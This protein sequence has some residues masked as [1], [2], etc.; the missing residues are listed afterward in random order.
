MANYIAR[1]LEEPLLR[2]SSQFPV[3]VLTGP[4]QCGKTTLLRHLQANDRRYVSLDLM[5]NRMLAKEDP[6]LF[7]QQ[8][9]PPCIIDEIQYA[10]EL[11]STIKAHADGRKDDKGLF[12]LT[13][14]QQ[15]RLMQ[16][17][18]ESLAGRAAVVTLNGLSNRELA[19]RRN[20]IAPFVPAGPPSAYTGSR[21]ASGQPLN[22]LASLFQRLYL[23]S[24]P[25][26]HSGEID[27]SLYYSSY[28]Q[29]YLERD[30]R[31]LSQVGN[32]E[33]F[34]TFLRVAAARTGAML[35]LSDMARDCAVSVPTVKHWL[36]ILTTTSI[37]YLLK[38]YATNRSLR[39]VKSPKLYFTDTGL[40]AHLAGYSS[41]ETL[42]ASPLRGAIFETWCVSEV[43]KSW[44]YS[45]REPPLYYF[46]DKDGNEIDL[47][48]ENDGRLHPVEIK[49]GA[50]PQKDWIKSFSALKKLGLPLGPGAVLSLT[51]EPFA[52]DRDISALPAGWI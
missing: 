6:E 37:I 27:S 30:V 4:R 9:P 28:I 12:W 36:S 50:T 51:S 2:A 17:V 21:D 31:E 19:L 43:L 18:T 16:G 7:L 45:L 13:G 42:A 11:L 29:T 26:L 52:L 32:V 15:F 10:P 47:I 24:Y 1:A 39:L 49:L 48:I 22:D 35:N 44:W 41:P 38:P 40:C 8:F 46:R 20:A 34:F 3:L 23:G 33:S 14:S 5:Q 25:A